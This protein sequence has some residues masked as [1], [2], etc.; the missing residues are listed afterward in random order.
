MYGSPSCRHKGRGKTTCV[1]CFQQGEM[2][3]NDC[4]ARRQTWSPGAQKNR[5]LQLVIVL[6][7]WALFEVVEGGSPGTSAIL[8]TLAIYLIEGPK[9]SRKHA[10]SGSRKPT[11]SH[12]LSSA[13]SR[14]SDG[15][16]GLTPNVVKGGGLTSIVDRCA[17]RTTQCLTPLAT[18][19]RMAAATAT[20]TATAASASAP[21]QTPAGVGE[22]SSFEASMTRLAGAAELGTEPLIY[23]RR[24]DVAKLVD[25][26][27]DI[28]RTPAPAGPA[29]TSP[30]LA[31]LNLVRRSR[32]RD[33]TPG[34]GRTAR[35]PVA[36]EDRPP[37]AFRRLGSPT[38]R[39]THRRSS[40]A[41]G[42]S[43]LREASASPASRSSP[44]AVASGGRALFQ[45]SSNS[46]NGGV[47]NRITFR[48]RSPVVDPSAAESGTGSGARRVR[49]AL[50]GKQ[51]RLRRRVCSPSASSS[52]SPPS[53]EVVDAAAAA[54][55]APA[56]AV[57]GCSSLRTVTM[58]PIALVKKKSPL[59]AASIDSDGGGGDLTSTDNKKEPGAQSLLLLTTMRDK[60][61]ASTGAVGEEQRLRCAPVI[62]RA[63]G[64][65]EGT[66]FDD[67]WSSGWG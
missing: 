33:R 61:I 67:I 6:V 39:S 22:E 24:T 49:G 17:D 29:V 3:G 66:D 65:R 45:D 59:I 7:H 38:L 44:A 4:A 5:M 47:A 32:R 58:T 30:A 13:E 63:S 50:E 56:P 26:L 42:G 23:V 34:K 18:A 12:G 1:A 16:V 48:P 46:G 60:N 19:P 20:A 8:F 10:T 25:V 54:V 43:G 11:R 35:S 52:S 57:A 21:P 31:R 9:K 51:R 36:R 28:A 64:K 40:G 14:H 27:M 41:V 55:A 53:A 62:R 2:A 15:P 37:S